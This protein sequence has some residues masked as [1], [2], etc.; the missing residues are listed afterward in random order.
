MCNFVGLTNVKINFIMELKIIGVESLGII[1]KDIEKKEMSV[2]GG[3][4]VWSFFLICC[5]SFK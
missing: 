4:M 3:P 2:D 5:Y 1:E